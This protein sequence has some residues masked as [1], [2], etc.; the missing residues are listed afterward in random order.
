MYYDVEIFVN[1]PNAIFSHYYTTDSLLPSLAS[2]SRW[3]EDGSDVG[4]GVGVPGASSLQMQLI[5]LV[6]ALLP[7]V[8]MYRETKPGQYTQPNGLL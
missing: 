4:A 2:R 5:S 7:A 3:S 6:Q 1:I 8:C